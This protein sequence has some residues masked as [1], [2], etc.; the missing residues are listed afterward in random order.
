MTFRLR[1]ANRIEETILAEE[2][3]AEK[4]KSWSKPQAEAK[5]ARLLKDDQVSRARLLAA[6]RRESGL[7]LHT[8]PT[9]TLGTLLD[10]ESKYC[11]CP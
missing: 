4:Q 11:T 9:L 7:R 2:R 5:A 3:D 6:A 8:L 1:R 10:S